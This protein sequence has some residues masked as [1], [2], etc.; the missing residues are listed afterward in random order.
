MRKKKT[1]I[2]ILAEFPSVIKEA[3]ENHSPA[4]IANYTFELVKQFNSFYQSV[5][6]LNEENQASK[7][8]RLVI[9]KN[10]AKVIH[11][12]MALLGIQVPNRM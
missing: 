9:S 5:P 8:A 6:I 2:K 7:L 12:A 1:I 10:V 11:H 3:G 4:L